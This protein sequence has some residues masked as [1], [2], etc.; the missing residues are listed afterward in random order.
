[1]TIGAHD[2]EIPHDMVSPCRDIVIVRIP[3]APNKIGS[4]HVPGITRDLAQ[5][6]SMGGVITSMGALAFAEKHEDGVKRVRVFLNREKTKWRDPQIGDWAVFRPF[7][8]TM[9]EGGKMVAS[10]GYR[11]MSSFNDVLG[12]VAPEF[13]KN[14]EN[15]TWDDDEPATAQEELKFPS[16][17]AK[18]SFAESVRERVVYKKEPTL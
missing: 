15:L 16:A 4:I 1:M 14:V 9:L 10:F 12:A 5:H 11:Y 7:A 3:R 8:G 18:D 2:F 6:N 17:S 13:M